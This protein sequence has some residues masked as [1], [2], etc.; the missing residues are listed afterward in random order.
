MIFI[1]FLNKI[2]KRHRR[3]KNVEISPI[4]QK[5]YDEAKKKMNLNYLSLKQ[6]EKI[7]RNN[8][9]VDFLDDEIK[10]EM[11]YPDIH[12]LADKLQPS[13][14]KENKRK[15]IVPKDIVKATCLGD[16]IG[17]TY[18][19]TD[20][21]YSATKTEMLP[22]PY[23]HFTDDTVLSIATMNA[24]LENKDNPDFRKHYI[25]EYKK[26][27]IAGY[28]S[29]F[30]GWASGRIN[31]KNGYHSMG[32][33]CAMRISFIASY[34]EDIQDVIKYT[35]KSCMTTHDHI[36]SIKG[37]VV[38]A[39][40]IWLALHNYTKEDIYDYCKEH[41]DYDTDTRKYLMY[42]WC[43]FDLRKELSSL[44][45]EQS[46]ETLF[47]NNAVPYAIKCF[48]E[49]NSY[50]ECMREILSHF[51]DTDTICAIAGG[52]CYAFYGK[53]EFDIEKILE[54]NDVK[55]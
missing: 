10:T 37:S 47:V 39:V 5:I 2:F 36:E 27:P 43:Q 50:E 46:K 53:A 14:K 33:G 49:T 40:C 7:I 23:S 12:F 11:N 20:H 18:E 26:F 54:N 51:G 17:S 25:E 52:L 19:F 21:D 8:K 6:I 30:I 9:D 28:G 15:N 3:T 41:Y 55:L 32:N 31:N 24:I 35:V 1:F 48:Y 38:I 29:S 16:I 45:N 4:K 34:Y 44:S 22:P 13:I 42:E